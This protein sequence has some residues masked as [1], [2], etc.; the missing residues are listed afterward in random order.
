MILVMV[1]VVCRHGEMNGDSYYI[2]LTEHDQQVNLLSHVILPNY[3]LA[4]VVVFNIFDDHEGVSIKTKGI[5]KL[6]NKQ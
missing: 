2:H 4:V 6:P 3:P 5:K 1:M